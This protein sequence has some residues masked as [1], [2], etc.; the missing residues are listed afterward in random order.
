MNTWNNLNLTDAKYRPVDEHLSETKDGYSC[1]VNVAGIKKENVKASLEKNVLKVSA[2]QD[3]H[4]Y[5]TYIMVPDK[6][7]P[8]SVSARCEDGML[9]LDLKKKPEHKSIELK[10]N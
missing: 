4:K 3:G 8:H 2:E 7:D 10:I 9:Y 6:V 5:K 1:Q